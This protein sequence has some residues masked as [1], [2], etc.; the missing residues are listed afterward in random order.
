MIRF[1]LN[2]FDYLEHKSERIRKDYGALLRKPEYSRQKEMI[3][4]LELL[5]N[6]GSIKKEKQLLVQLLDGV[7]KESSSDTDIINYRD[8]LKGKLN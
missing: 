4:V 7:L 2:D 1:E 5:M 8:W 3:R 6:T